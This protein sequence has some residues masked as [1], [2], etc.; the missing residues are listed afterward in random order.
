MRLRDVESGLVLGE[1][2]DD[3]ILA[4]YQPSAE[5]TGIIV[6]DAEGNVIEPSM[7]KLGMRRVFV[8]EDVN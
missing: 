1:A 7:A 4:S 6:I 2:T 8:D 3:Q 5:P